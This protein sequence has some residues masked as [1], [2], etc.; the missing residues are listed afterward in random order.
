MN[1]QSLNIDGAYR[2][3]TEP[4]RDIRGSF[5]VFWEESHWPMEFEP[6]N[7]YHSY[8]I[9]SGTLRGMHFQKSPHGQAKLVTCV[10]GSCF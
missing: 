6:V 5:S 7:A 2:I 9:Q 8:N 1:I 10:R 4:F 3:G